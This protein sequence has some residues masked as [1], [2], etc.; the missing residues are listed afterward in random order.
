MCFNSPRI[1]SAFTLLLL[2]NVPNRDMVEV[3]EGN[4]AIK[5]L[6]GCI[7]PVTTLDS[8]GVGWRS[9]DATNKLEGLVFPILKQGGKVWLI[10][11]EAA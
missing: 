5:E 10:I 2:K 8:P 11:Q 6:N 4:W 9:G 7:A 1:G 3:Y